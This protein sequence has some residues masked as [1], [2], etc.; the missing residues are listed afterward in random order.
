MKSSKQGAFQ[1]QPFSFSH[2]TGTGLRFSTSGF[3][4]G[5]GFWLF[6]LCPFHVGAKRRRELGGRRVGERKACSLPPFQACFH[7]APNFRLFI[8]EGGM[9]LCQPLL[10]RTSETF[11]TRVI[12]S[13]VTCPCGDLIVLAF[14]IWRFKGGTQ[15]TECMCKFLMVQVAKG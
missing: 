14:S 4:S 9:A 11:H 12:S 5:V 3:C 15:K 2:A 7:L 13:V 1:V 10:N 8:K 6:F